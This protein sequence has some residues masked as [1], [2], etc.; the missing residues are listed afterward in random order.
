MHEALLYEKLPDARVRCRTCQWRC[1]INPGKFGACGMYQNQDGALFNLN[2]ARVSSIAVDPIEK[3][4]LFHFHPGTQ[5]LSLGTLGCNFQCQHCQNWEISTADSASLVNACRELYPKASITLAREYRC[6][7]IA[8]TYNEPTIWFEHTLES[9]KLAK[10]SGLYTV[11]VTNGYATPEALDT[12]GPYLDAWR[13]DI[14]GFSDEF[15]KTLAGVPRWREILEVTARAKNKWKM[16]VEV[17]TNIVPTLNDDD[18]QLEGIANW[19][20]SELGELTP[21]HVTRFQPHHRLTHL[22]STPLATIDRACEI[23]RRAGLKF[24]YAGNVPGHQSES[25]RCYAC[26]QT[27]VNRLGYQTDVIGLQGTRCRHCGADL[28]FRSADAKEG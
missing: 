11:Y 26:G 5:C 2:Y 19:I 21:W 17:V 16:H 14:K 8:W 13:V 15:Y 20:K 27:A 4:P 9:A 25:T 12:I 3:K 6:Q 1:R 24:I 7:G 23:G 28:N 22:P 18:K 10:E